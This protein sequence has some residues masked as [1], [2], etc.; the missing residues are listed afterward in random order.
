MLQYERHRAALRQLR[1]RETATVFRRKVSGIVSERF[2]DGGSYRQRRIIGDR[3][4]VRRSFEHDRQ[5][6]IRHFERRKYFRKDFA[7]NTLFPG[8]KLTDSIFALQ[9]C[10]STVPCNSS[11]LIRQVNAASYPATRRFLSVKNDSFV[12][13]HY[14]GAVEYSAD[15]LLS[16]NNDKVR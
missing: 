3:A 12:I 10:L 11:T 7:D 8:V 14:A 13:Q 9:V 5:V 1:Q 4:I 6:F 15:D 16:K 2:A